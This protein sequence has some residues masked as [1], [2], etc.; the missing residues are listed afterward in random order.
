LRRNSKSQF[1]MNTPKKLVH[2][3]L[4]N[5][6]TTI[7]QVSIILSKIQSCYFDSH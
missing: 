4:L 5:Y 1:K 3:H 2:Y 6:T 7:I